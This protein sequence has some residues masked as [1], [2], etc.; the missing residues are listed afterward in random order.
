MTV[1]PGHPNQG[2]IRRNA[3]LFGVVLTVLGVV[4][5]IGGIVVFIQAFSAD[6]DPFAEEGIPKPVF[7][8]LGIFV[9]GILLV[10]GRSLLAAGYGGAALRYAAGEAAPVL[11]DTLAYL[12][13]KETSAT[14]PFCS[15]CGV[16]NDSDARFCDACGAQLA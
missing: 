11:K 1:E 4:V 9:G 16:R 14:G 8:M 15:K 10:L 5:V 13:D 6:Y 3:R 12:G 2:L 7:G